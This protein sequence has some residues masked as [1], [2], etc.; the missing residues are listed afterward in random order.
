MVQETNAKK[1]G[2][3]KLDNYVM[4]ESKR[5]KVGGGSLMGV[6]EQLNPVLISLYENEFE[7][8]VVETNIGK[9][10]IR[11][12]TSYGPQEDVPVEVKAPFFLALDQEISKAVSNGCAVYVAMDINSKLGKEYI[13][14]DSNP[15]SKNGDI[16][17]EIIDRNA[18]TVANCLKEK[19]NGVI[20]RQ[21]NTVDGRCE[22]SVIDIVLISSNIEDQLISMNIDEE[23][24]FVLTKIVKK[25]NS[26]VKKT[27]SDHNIIETKFLIKITNN[28]SKPKQE[29]YNLKN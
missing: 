3:H 28:T 20:T 17:A 13:P 6:H 14:Q 22:K 4:F 8:I 12:I 5:T 29:M 1:K 7:L 19:C 21:R 23:Q 2:K 15:M 9:K 18:L 26:E 11:F 27:E 16:L 25:H 24:K 10:R